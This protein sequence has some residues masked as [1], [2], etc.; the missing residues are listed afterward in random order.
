MVLIVISGIARL[1]NYAVLRHPGFGWPAQLQNEGAIPS[2]IVSAVPLHLLHTYRSNHASPATDDTMLVVDT[3]KHK[4]S[5]VT[6][7]QFQAM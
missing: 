3:A 5:P 2:I 4:T 6:Q 1:F 7:R